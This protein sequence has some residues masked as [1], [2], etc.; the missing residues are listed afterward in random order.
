MTRFRNPAT[1]D[2]LNQIMRRPDALEYLLFQSLHAEAA[3]PE[4]VKEF[5]A[6]APPEVS[7]AVDGLLP[8]T[9][10]GRHIGPAHDDR[11]VQGFVGW[12]LEGK[13]GAR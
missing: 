5:L 13:G 12:L 8:V 9:T 11:I 3:T 2:R 4:Q 10:D 7:I 1:Q 6:T